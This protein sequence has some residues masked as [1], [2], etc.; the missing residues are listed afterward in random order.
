[1]KRLFIVVVLALLLAAGGFWLSGGRLSDL[2]WMTAAVM[3]TLGFETKVVVPERPES[4]PQSAAWIGG[5]DGGAWIECSLDNEK[6]ANWCTAWSDQ[7]GAVW[8]RTYFVLRDSGEPVP[9][10]E[11]RYSGFSGTYIE[12]ADGRVMEPLKFHG[13]ED[14]VLSEPTPID[15]P[16]D[17]PSV[18]PR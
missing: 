12:L 13:D 15:P 11:L 4:V 14:R 17:A 8:A 2:W 16:L 18:D 3:E 1:M 6:R 5:V 10:S 9:E 7:T